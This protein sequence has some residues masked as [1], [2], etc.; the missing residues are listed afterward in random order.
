MYIA[1][2][3]GRTIDLTTGDMGSELSYGLGKVLDTQNYS[4]LRLASSHY[5]L[6]LNPIK[7]TLNIASILSLSHTHTRTNIHLTINMASIIPNHTSIMLVIH[8]KT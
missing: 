4:N 2:S 3:R 1:S 7:G 8:H 5:V 6:C